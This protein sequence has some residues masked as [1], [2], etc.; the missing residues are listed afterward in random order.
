M[1]R[2]NASGTFVPQ[3]QPL[4]IDNSNGLDLNT[5]FKQLAKVLEDTKD[6]QGRI[7]TI[8]LF[9]NEFLAKYNKHFNQS[10]NDYMITELKKEFI[11]GQFYPTKE[12]KA[13]LLR[14]YNSEFIPAKFYKRNPKMTDLKKYKWFKYTYKSFPNSDEHVNGIQII[15]SFI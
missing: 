5:Y 7:Q 15:S 12:A 8:L 14:I 6:K 10:L 11:V 2:Y 9:K 4:T 3:E 1:N 13:K